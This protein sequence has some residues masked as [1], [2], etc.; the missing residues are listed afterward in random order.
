MI[1]AGIA[2]HV[3]DPS[4]AQFRHMIAVLKSKPKATA[5]DLEAA[6]KMSPS[7]SNLLR[8]GD[9]YY[10]MGNYS[11]AAEIYRQVAAKPGAD[12]DV[13]NLHLGMAL[14]RAGDKAGA[15]AALNSVT[16]RARRHRK[17]L[18]ALR[19]AARLSRRRPLE[20]EG[21]SVLPAPFS[22]AHGRRLVYCPVSGWLRAASLAPIE[23][24]H[25]ADGPY[26]SE[27]T[28]DSLCA[29]TIAC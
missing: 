2:A 7:A 12:K 15:T 22:F 6:M 25:R 27:R 20:K 17:I 10:G 23:A 11:K 26:L 18:A 13:A 14:A 9:R 5:A 8:I 21:A 3:V 1:D 28:W 29:S 4:T 16:G 24:S 19:A